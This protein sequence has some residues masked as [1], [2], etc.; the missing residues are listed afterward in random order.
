MIKLIEKFGFGVV[1]RVYLVNQ[2]T[3]NPP[4]QRTL[5]VGPTPKACYTRFRK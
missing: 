2:C 4:Q 5:G 1:T 3:D